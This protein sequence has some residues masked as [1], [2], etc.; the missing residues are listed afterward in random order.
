MMRPTAHIGEMIDGIFKV[1]RVDFCDVDRAQEAEIDHNNCLYVRLYVEPS[2]TGLYL[3][4]I[5]PEEV[6]AFF[7]QEEISGKSIAA[8]L[9]LKAT[10]FSSVGDRRAVPI[11]TIETA[12][13]SGINS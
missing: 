10:H 1:G 8:K 4:A 13:L 2:S 3:N 6:A 9:K 12:K 5:A 7:E 11:I